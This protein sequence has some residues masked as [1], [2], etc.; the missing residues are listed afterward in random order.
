MP[1]PKIQIAKGSLTIEHFSTR[2]ECVVTYMNGFESPKRAEALHNMLQLGARALAYAASQSDTMVFVDVVKASSESAKTLLETVS[3]QARQSADDLPKKFQTVLKTIE[4]DLVK[5]LDPGKASSVL[6]KLHSALVDSVA[7]ETTKLSDALDIRNPRSGL[8]K[9]L[10]VIEKRDVEMHAQLERIAAELQAR[11]AA[12]AVRRKT[13]GKGV[14]FEDMLEAY[15]ADESRPRHDIVERTSKV[16]GLEGTDIG[17]ITIEVDKAAAGGAGLRLVLEAKDSQIGLPALVREIASAMRN[18]GAAFGIGV[19]TNTDITRGSSLI[20][21]VG[22]DKFI[23]CAPPCGDNEFELLGVSIALEMARWKAI[24]ARME[25]GKPLDLR[26]LLAHVDAMGTS[27]RR[28]S[29]GKRKLTSM[30]AVVDEASAYY[31]AIRSDIQ[32][33]LAGLREK[34]LADLGD[35]SKAA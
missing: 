1:T 33:Q 31:D 28:F 24:R 3:K 34:I 10:T 7:K 17:D 27:L 2:D 14:A 8:A 21:P 11:N 35:Q 15:V 30:K 20:I 19:T 16:T 22:D 6:G 5:V 23:V 29:E 13:S 32:S 26:A 18:R 4:S 12:G 9:I 25:P